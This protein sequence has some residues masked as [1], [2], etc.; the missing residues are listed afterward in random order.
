M[1]ESFRINVPSKSKKAIVLDREGLSGI[2]LNVI[3][4]N[5][6]TAAQDPKDHG[7]LD[8]V[9]SDKNTRRITAEPLCVDQINVA[10]N[11]VIYKR[12]RIDQ[13]CRV[14]ALYGHRIQNIER[15]AN[16]QR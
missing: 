11:S 13:V 9:V 5:Y 10:E 6:R 4:I 7:Q 2:I 16:Y 1:N 3:E 14:K 12:N 15:I 8:L